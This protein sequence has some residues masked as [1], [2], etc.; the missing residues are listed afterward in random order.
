MARV[1]GWAWI[2]AVAVGCGDDGKDEESGAA[3]AEAAEPPAAEPTREPTVDEPGEPDVDEAVPAEDGDAEPQAASADD[4][5]G[6]PEQASA[7]ADE[8]APKRAERQDRAHRGSREERAQERARMLED[9]EL[10]SEQELEA[11]TA[12]GDP[13]DYD[14]VLAGSE[15]SGRMP[16]D[17]GPGRGGDEQSDGEG[18]AVDDGKRGLR[19]MD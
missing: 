15:V 9:G 7:E 1:V 4:G 16:A 14:A 5:T 3:A 10:M 6:Q 13:D 19:N 8:P 12:T 11:I 2:L 17:E 18:D